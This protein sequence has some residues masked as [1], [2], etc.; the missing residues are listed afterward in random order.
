MN[1]VDRFLRNAR[2][3]K[4]KIWKFELS[5]P[6]QN[7]KSQQFTY[8]SLAKGFLRKVCGNSAES[9]RKF[10]KNTFRCVRKVCR[11]SAESCGNLRNIFWNDPFPNDPMSELL[12]KEGKKGKIG[13]NGGKCYWQ[14]VCLSSVSVVNVL[15]S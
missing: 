12:K 10:D 13:R 5:P 15:P 14:F 8:G 11:N 4:W 6:P 2:L 9:S 7:G 1:L 3:R